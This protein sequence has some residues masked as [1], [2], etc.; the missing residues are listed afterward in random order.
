MPI[1]ILNE[2]GRESLEKADH[3]LILLEASTARKKGL[4]EVLNF[5][6]AKLKAKILDFAPVRLKKIIAGA[7]MRFDLNPKTR[8]TVKLVASKMST[9]SQLERSRKMVSCVTSNAARNAFIDLRGIEAK[10]WAESLTSAFTANSFQSPKYQKTPKKESPEKTLSLIVSSEDQKEVKSISDK[11]HRKALGTNLV[12]R[13]SLMAGNDLTTDRYVALATELAKAANLK[14]EFF[15]FEKLKTMGAGA[16]CAVAQGAA[17]KSG[18]LKIQYT[19]ETNS[20]HIAFV[21]KGV[22]YD[23]GGAQIKTGEH[24]FGMHGD[25]GGSAVALALV[26][27]AAEEKV[28]YSVTAYLAI[29]DN[30]FSPTSYRPNDVVTSLCGKT[31]EVVDT[32]AEGRMILADT[33][34]LASQSKPDLMMDFATLTGSCVRAIGTNY[35]GGYSNRS[36]LLSLIRRAGKKSGERVWPFPNDKDYGRCLKSKVADI[37]QCRLKGGVDH[38]EASYFLRQFVE[39]SVPYVHVDLSAIEHEGGLAQVSSEN[40]GFGVRFATEF[41]EIFLNRGMKNVSL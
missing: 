22:T 41:V 17:G 37:K 14:T 27:W 29:T 35:S 2:K 36:S 3:L 40:T 7:Q 30:Q 13:L 34:T 32:D 4:K 1:K 38:I 24:M 25:M 15:G 18:I 28:P 31:I 26:L 16:F 23:T 5:V 20:P 8:V 39:N 10:K 19:A 9:F 33:L 21:G 11:A 6:D 12:R